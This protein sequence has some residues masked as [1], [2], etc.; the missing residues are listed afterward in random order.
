MNAGHG[1][2]ATGRRVTAL[3]VL[4]GVAVAVVVDFFGGSLGSLGRVVALLAGLV[5]VFV[6]LVVYYARAGAGPER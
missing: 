2:L 5:V 1:P 3:A 6:V 4:V